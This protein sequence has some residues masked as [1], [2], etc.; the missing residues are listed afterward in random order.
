ME[1]IPMGSR[2]YPKIYPPFPRYT[3][4][5][6]KNKFNRNKFFSPE[7]GFLFEMQWLWTEKID[8]T[9]IRVHWD[10]NRVTYGGKSDNA[11]IPAKL[12]P[13]LND[14]FPEELFEQIWGADS[15][16]LY[17]EGYGAGIQ[18]GG[19]YRPDQS[20]ILFD[21]LS[22][23]EQGDI[24]LHD[25]NV[26]SVADKFG[27]ESV[28]HVG[29]FTP[30]DVVNYVQEGLLLPGHTPKCLPDRVEGYVGR[31]PL[32]LLNRKGERIIMKVKYGDFDD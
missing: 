17:G 6:L 28:P 25:I 29:Y 12:L 3:E 20:F 1:Y 18:S 8:G 19:I 32:G 5:L 26:I 31:A 30:K 9:N 21:I 10:G 7:V 15:F 27:I 23:S 4:G 13:A 16:T 11:Q 24:W 22:H 2:K 14:M